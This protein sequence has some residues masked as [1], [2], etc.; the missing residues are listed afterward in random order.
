MTHKMS[1]LA[2]PK[3]CGRCAW[4]HSIQGQ[5]SRQFLDLDPCIAETGRQMFCGKPGALHWLCLNHTV[6]ANAA[7]PFCGRRGKK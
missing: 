4:D 7:W 3:T 2:L 5:I 6:E 1:L